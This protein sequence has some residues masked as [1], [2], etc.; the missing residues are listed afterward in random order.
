MGHH[1]EIKALPDKD[2]RDR[3]AEPHAPPPGGYWGAIRATDLCELRKRLEVLERFVR[4]V[5]SV[6]IAIDCLVAEAEELL[7]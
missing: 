2:G 7:R 5:A 6:G 3:P 4:Q 1:D